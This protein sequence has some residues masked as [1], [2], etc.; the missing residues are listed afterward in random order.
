MFRRVAIVTAIAYAQ[1]LPSIV[2]RENI[3][4]A[5]YLLIDIRRLAFIRGSC[6][7]DVVLY[8]TLAF[9]K[10]T[11]FCSLHSDCLSVCLSVGCFYSLYSPKQPDSPPKTTPPYLAVILWKYEVF[12]K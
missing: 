1:Q 7:Y 12:W 9:Q 4:R 8:A 5:T 11:L 2:Y 10:A 6:Q 3:A